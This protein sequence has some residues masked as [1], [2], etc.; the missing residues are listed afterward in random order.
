MKE[1][2][3]QILA[4]ATVSFIAIAQAISV[5]SIH[6]IGEFKHDKKKRFKRLCDTIDA[7]LNTK[8]SNVTD[9]DKVSSDAMEGYIHDM[10]YD[11]QSQYEVEVT[12]NSICLLLEFIYKKYI[13]SDYKHK[14]KQ[15]FVDA[16][17]I[18]YN[19]AIGKTNSALDADLQHF[20]ST[21]IEGG[22]Y[23][24]QIKN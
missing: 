5:Q 4:N 14:E 3:L 16:Y 19:Y 11:L 2:E 24:K 9:S 23:V 17:T 10:L 6:F 1:K 20:I 18:A 13:Y 8:D 12:F 22:E 21:L 15:A 7:F